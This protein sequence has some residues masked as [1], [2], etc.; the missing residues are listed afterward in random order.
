MAI[1]RRANRKPSRPR[2]T[3]GAVAALAAL[4]VATSVVGCKPKYEATGALSIGDAAFATTACH[5]RTDAT[6]IELLD[7]AGSRVQLTLPPARLEAFRE[8]QGT[9]EVRY[10]PRGKPAVDLGRCGTLLLRG[11]GYH[12]PSRRAASGRLSLACSGNAAA[13]GELSFA[14]CF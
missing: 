1:M 4:L 14:G 3:F 7:A 9:A 8:M 13:S 2:T 5:V 10:E 6:G 11:E 12:E